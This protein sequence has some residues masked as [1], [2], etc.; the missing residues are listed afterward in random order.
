[1]LP[2]L[3][4]RETTETLQHVNRACIARK[5]TVGGA[6]ALGLSLARARQQMFASVQSAVV[7]APDGGTAPMLKSPVR[8]LLSDDPVLPAIPARS[9]RFLRPEESESIGGIVC[10]LCPTAPLNA[11]SSTDPVL[12]V[13]CSS[14]PMSGV[15]P[16][17]CIV[18]IASDSP[19][20]SFGSPDML[21]RSDG[22]ERGGDIA[23]TS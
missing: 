1:M 13:T 9:G 10:V 7:C 23:S 17:A 19:R 3:E 21:A 16:E 15:D 6:K 18:A 20:C 11:P 2:A 14:T 12:S 5:L 8:A 4:R 22:S